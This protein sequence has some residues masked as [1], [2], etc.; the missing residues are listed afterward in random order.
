MTLES[1]EVDFITPD[2][3]TFS[4]LSFLSFLVSRGLQLSSS[5]GILSLGLYWDQFYPILIPEGRV[6]KLSCILPAAGCTGDEFLTYTVLHVG[7]KYTI[8]SCP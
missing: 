1:N 6:L 7:F 5:F 2:D 4:S 3:M 8:L